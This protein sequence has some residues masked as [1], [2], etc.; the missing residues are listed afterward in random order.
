MVFL[1]A[2]DQED[3]QIDKT[4]LEELEEFSGIAGVTR[5][6]WENQRK[7]VSKISAYISDNAHDYA[8]LIR[9]PTGSGKTGITAVVTNCIERVECSLVVVPS[10]TLVEQMLRDLRYAFWC[11][12]KMKPAGN[13]RPVFRLYPRTAEKCIAFLSE[14]IIGGVIVTTPHTFSKIYSSDLAHNWLKNL[15]AKRVRA[16]FRGDP[17]QEHVK[18]Y[19]E[20]K[21]KLDLVVFDEGHREPAKEW[22]RAV[23]SLEKPCVL[24][25]ATPYRNDLRR[26]RIGGESFREEYKFGEAVAKDIIREVRFY[27]SRVKLEDDPRAFVREVRRCFKIVERKAKAQGICEPKVIV[28]CASFETLCRIHSEFCIQEAKEGGKG[29]RKARI[30]MAFHSRFGPHYTDPL[31]RYC[32]QELQRTIRT[33]RLS[34][35]EKAIR[36]G[37]AQRKSVKYWIHQDMLAE[38]VDVPE[39]VFLAFYE[40][41]KNSR[42]MVQ[43]IGRILR[44]T[45]PRRQHQ[46]AYVL[47]DSTSQMEE[48][49]NAYKA[50]EDQSTSVIGAID[51]VDSI[52]KALPELYY[53][54]RRYRRA[55]DP[56]SA[57]ALKNDLRLPARARV[58]RI[59]AD[60]IAQ[61]TFGFY[62]DE[63]M[64]ELSEQLEERD[65]VEMTVPLS[66]KLQGDA[67]CMVHIHAAQSPHLEEGG[68]FDIRL[69]PSVFVRRGD[70][71][72]HT[73]EVGLV[74]GKF[75]RLLQPVDESALQAILLQLG[76]QVK[77][78]SLVSGDLGDTAVRRKA[79]GARDLSASAPNLDDHFHFISSAMTVGSV[80]G[81]PVRRYVSFSRNAISETC[82]HPLS[83]DEYIAWVDSLLQTMQGKVPENLFLGRFAPHTEPKTDDDKTPAHI[84]VELT[85]FRQV[86]E[87]THDVIESGL[88]F[89]DLFSAIACPVEEDPT[90]EG[91]FLWQAE[92][93]GKVASGTIRYLDDRKRFILKSRQLDEAFKQRRREIQ[94]GE[95]GD[96]VVES[97]V[98]HRRIR[99]SSFLT[100]RA[101]VRVITKS[102]LLYAD[103]RF[104]KPT[105]P[106][107]G[108]RRVEEIGVLE[109]MMELGS[110]RYVDLKQ[111]EK[112][113][114]YDATGRKG[115]KTKKYKYDKSNGTWAQGSLFHFIDKNPILFQQ[116]GWKHNEIYLVCDDMGEETADFVA[117][118]PKRDRVAVIHAKCGKKEGGS[119]SATDFKEVSSQVV[120]NLGL[121][122]PATPYSPDLLSRWRKKWPAN[123]KN[124]AGLDRIRRGPSE[125]KPSLKEVIEALYRVL[126]SPSSDKEAWIVNSYGIRPDDLKKLLKETENNKS[127]PRYN[128]IQLLYLMHSCNSAVSSQRARLR[129]FGMKKA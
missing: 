28:R 104:Y 70:L 115:K 41:F 27:V 4:C 18:L 76:D 118:D 117:I 7:A 89:G 65:L 37:S 129:I 36:S 43:Q 38:G 81:L 15:P 102:G 45:T 29:K 10:I 21:D 97:E 85:E 74:G 103:R 82:H 8:A 49:W 59:P 125:M 48:Q 57:D 87:G 78:V 91:V 33:S 23:R 51:I 9:A 56:R 96:N 14:H 25:S 50:Y 19:K 17:V 26:F 22:A 1:E 64:D 60:L 98:E 111:R 94:R 79:F 112:G 20:L 54:G 11:K 2:M 124:G 83:L 12:I 44:N 84:L 72:F 5:S 105:I 110:D 39:F 116:A 90:R 80:D 95:G 114:T 121:F 30:A 88:P 62:I 73:G 55:T 68:F 128:I 123:G 34:T 16:F 67:Y 107:W 120:K 109:S 63:L 77:Q 71:L 13:P 93:L 3:R 86:F 69:S 40:E 106:L 58:F 32:P 127:L 24:M 35:P 100:T 113:K 108:K 101:A 99:A 46:T 126:S 31:M 42:S 92:I 61:E 6:L 53:G 119:F 47:R 75:G 66:R 52:R 122:N